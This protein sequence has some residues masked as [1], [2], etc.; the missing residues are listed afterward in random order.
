M[1]FAVHRE[2]G[3]RVVRVDA[4]ANGKRRLTRT[5][6]DIRRVELTGLP[7]KGPLKVR[8]A[9]TYNTDARSVSVQS[10]NGCKAG[11]PSV[12]VIRDDDSPESSP[13]DSR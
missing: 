2:P 6:H 4:Y 9:A 3:A 11:R 7:R 12:Q 10:W 5:G 8:I 13:G 1:A